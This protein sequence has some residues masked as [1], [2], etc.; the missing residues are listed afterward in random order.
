MSLPWFK[1][2]YLLTGLAILVAH[3]S[4]SYYGQ[5]RFHYVVAPGDDVFVHYGLIKAVSAHPSLWPSAYYPPGFHYLILGVSH[6]LNLSVMSAMIWAWPLLLILAALAIW[7]LSTKLFGQ[8]IGLLTYILY[9]FLSLQPLQT[10]NDGSLPNVLAGNT[11]LPVAVFLWYRVW[12]AEAQKRWYSLALFILTSGLILYTHHLSTFIL[13][14]V[15]ASSGLALGLSAAWRSQNRLRNTV[16][17][18]LAFI[19]LGLISYFAF[20]HLPVFG[21][22]RY[23]LSAVEKIASQNKVFPLHAFVT[24]IS[25]VIAFFGFLGGLLLLW[26]LKDRNLKWED[27]VARF[28]ILAWFAIYFF[29]SRTNLVGEPERLG[30]DWAMPGVLAAAYC[31]TRISQIVKLEITRRIFIGLVAVAI[32]GN[33]YIKFTLLTHYDSMIRFSDADTAML[34]KVNSLPTSETVFIATNSLTRGAWVVQAAKEVASGK[35]VFVDMSHAEAVLASQNDSCVA[36]SYNKAQVWPDEF[37]DSSTL[38]AL[39][40]IPGVKSDYSVDDPNKIWYLLCTK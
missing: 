33:F 23:L 38:L 14:A 12:T 24:S 13:G 36:T 9:V 11:L 27:R 8:K 37:H 20:W 26:E 10:A 30:R 16:S 25:A 7:L 18:L 4:L 29:G 22:E 2:P 34:A 35:I 6:V 1:R 21:P 15:V 5:W 32:I 31:I 3:F 19:S 39:I 28:I 17:V 40:K